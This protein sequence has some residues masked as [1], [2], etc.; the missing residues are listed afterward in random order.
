MTMKAS[1]AQLR[2]FGFTMAVPLAL[3]AGLLFWRE[4]QA[5]TWLAGVAVAFAIAALAT[6]SLLRPIE[7]AWMKLA[8]VLSIVMTSVLLTLTYYLVMTPMGFLMKLLGKDPMERKFDRGKESYW[9][10]IDPDGPAS[11][12]DKPF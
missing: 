9:I 3:I 1:T 4:N 12:P 7:W 2:K 6:P 11:R 10:A 8:H 5:W